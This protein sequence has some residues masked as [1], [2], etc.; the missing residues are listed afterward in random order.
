M[1][2]SKA[3]TNKDWSEL[4]TASSSK[5]TT[6]KKKTTTARKKTTTKTTA[7]KETSSTKKEDSGIKYTDD[8]NKF[9]HSGFPIRLEY[10]DGKDKK[11]C[12]FQCEEHFTKHVTRYKL[13]PKEYEVYTNN[14]AL[15]GSID[16]RKSPQK[17]Q[18][19][20]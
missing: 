8:S 9:P 1:R 3:K 18:S 4:T 11:I 16:G 13:N 14:V 10:T 2:T 17:R 20:R 15:V 7:K 5:K 6:T 12:W 19:S